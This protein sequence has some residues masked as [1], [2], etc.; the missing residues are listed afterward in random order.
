MKKIVFLLAIFINSQANATTIKEIKTPGGFNA[1]LVEEHSQPLVSV[2]STSWYDGLASQFLVSEFSSAWNEGLGGLYCTCACPLLLEGV[3]GSNWEA[4]GR[5]L[6][7]GR[8][9][10]LFK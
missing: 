5:L 3:C 7:S 9:D 6:C 1:W 4:D 10:I 8:L 2:F